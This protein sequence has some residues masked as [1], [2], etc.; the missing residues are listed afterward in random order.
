MTDWDDF[1]RLISPPGEGTPW[2][3]DFSSDRH[4]EYVS[5][6]GP[7]TV[8]GGEFTAAPAFLQ[9][10]FPEVLG[11]PVVGSTGRLSIKVVS[12]SPDGDGPLDTESNVL[13]V[14]GG[15]YA[16]ISWDWTRA[17]PYGTLDASGDNYTQVGTTTA[18]LGLVTDAP[19]GSIPG[20]FPGIQELGAG[21]DAGG[22]HG[23]AC[24]ATSPGGDIDELLPFDLSTLTFPFWLAL[25]VTPDTATAE[26]WKSDPN[27]GGSPV[28]SLSTPY[29]PSP[30]G[31]IWESGTAHTSAGLNGSPAGTGTFS[32]LRW[33]PVVQG[34]SLHVPY[35]FG[36][37]EGNLGVSEGVR[38]QLAIAQ[39]R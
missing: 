1:I 10:F 9:A 39:G 34:A 22:Y 26:L 15:A 29:S 27:D 16:T 23:G 35:P 11:A 14:V 3:D 24:F 12:M 38:G 19:D 7:G 25:N 17:A 4:A 5:A 18:A 32:D 30:T 31:L 28:L 37:A 2:F 21:S 8:S 6:Y 36:T 13:L 33:H 20:G